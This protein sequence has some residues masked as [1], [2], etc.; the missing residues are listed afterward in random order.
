MQAPK[1]VPMFRKSRPVLI[2][3]ICLAGS[4]L[5]SGPLTGVRAQTEKQKAVPQLSQH[6]NRLFDRTLS[7]STFQQEVQRARD[8]GGPA[9]L[10]F[11]AKL[12]RY[13]RTGNQGALADLAPDMEKVS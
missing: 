3:A 7:D 13:L 2:A 9:Q 6:I 10:L 4:E 5:V 8:A 12:V 11:E 1:E